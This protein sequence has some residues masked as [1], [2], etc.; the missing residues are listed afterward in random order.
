MITIRAMVNKWQNVDLATEV[1][2]II[3]AQSDV[4]I[5]YNQF[6]LYNQSLLATGERLALYQNIR[7]AL[8]KEKLNPIPGFL[9]P[10]LKLTGDFYAGFIITV[11][12]PY[13]YFSST[14]IKTDELVL[15]FTQYIFGL[16]AQSK[17]QY[18]TTEFWEALKEYI[19]EITGCTFG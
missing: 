2:N 6:Q 4:L 7:Y 16:T 5:K 8:D 3:R 11:K 15:N 9:H 13:I 17:T 12:P 14:D 10:D 1:P 18:A 19:T